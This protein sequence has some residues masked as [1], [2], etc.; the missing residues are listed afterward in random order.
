MGTVN[1]SVSPT[2]DRSHEGVINDALAAL[3]RERGLNAVELEPA[4]TVDSDA[5]SHLE[6]E[7]DGQ[8]VQ[9]TFAVAAGFE[10]NYRPLTP[11][12]LEQ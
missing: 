12:L 11:F 2:A 5:L 10:A 6:M 4:L 8:K 7:V 1:M 3:F 9:V